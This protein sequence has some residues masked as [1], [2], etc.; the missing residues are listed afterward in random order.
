M[1]ILVF[2]G[3]GF[4]GS[5]IVKCL[6]QAGYIVS[7]LAR[8]QEKALVVKQMGAIPCPGDLKMPETIRDA[9]KGSDLIVNTAFPSFLG[10]MTISTEG[11]ADSYNSV[12]P[13]R[14]EWLKKEIWPSLQ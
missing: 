14:R 4:I 2:G 5:Q 9:I 8:S 11:T 7:A 10:R 12:C 6:V 3:T 1:K 13:T